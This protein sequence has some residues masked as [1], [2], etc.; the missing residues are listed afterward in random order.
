MITT[1]QRLAAVLILTSLVG[2]CAQGARTNAMV[3]AVTPDTLVDEGSPLT[4]SSTV[5]SVTGGTETNPLWT[6]EISD[7][8]FKQALEQS[9]Q[10]HAILAPSNGRLSVTAA[11]KEVDQPF[12]GASFTVTST[13]AYK[14]VDPTGAVVFEDTVVKPYTAEFSDA[15]LGAERLRL[16]NEGSAR[17]N[18][19]EF[20]KRLV[21][22]SKAQPD[23]FAQ[24]PVT[25]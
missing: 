4:A 13:V 9:L 23:L 12:I 3:A 8:A 10:L 11:L 14:V 19:A 6:S 18:I 2:A 22:A 5:V 15:F 21:A 17:A 7:A 1:I 16:A 24:A 25:S 20:I